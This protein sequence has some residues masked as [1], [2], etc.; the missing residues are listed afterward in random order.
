MYILWVLGPCAA[1]GFSFGLILVRRAHSEDVSATLVCYQNHFIS[2]LII[3]NK[4][5][6]LYYLIAYSNNH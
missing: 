3:G 1:G 2:R 4:T 6:K 5:I